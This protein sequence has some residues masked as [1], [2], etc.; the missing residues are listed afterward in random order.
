VLPALLTL[1]GVS[2]TA[3]G[4]DSLVTPSPSGT[5]ERELKKS[6]SPPESGDDIGAELGGT[7]AAD[8][9]DETAGGEAVSPIQKVVKEEE[10]ESADNVGG[11]LT[12]TREIRVGLFEHGPIAELYRLLHPVRNRLADETGI[13][14]GVAYTTL[15]QAVTA[16][17]DPREGLSG[18]FDFFGKWNLLN[19]NQPNT[20]STG[21]L[22]EYRHR[23]TKITPNALNDN[24]GS[25]WRTTKAFNSQELALV[26]LWWEQYLFSDHAK[27]VA[28][29]IDAANFYNGNR[30]QNQNTSFL[31]QAFSTNPTR[32]FP[33]NGLGINVRLAPSE[34]IY[35]SF[36]VH[37]ANSKKTSFNFDDL[38][39]DDLFYA[40]EFG[41]T[42]RFEGFGP[43][44]YRFTGWHI[45]PGKRTN[46]KSGSGFALSF[47]QDLGNSLVPFFRYGYQA[48]ELEATRQ[49]VVGG[50]GIESPF[51]WKDD[52]LGIGFA[53]GDPHET[54]L[55]DQYV[56]ELYLQHRLTP[57]IQFTP[58]LQLIFDPSFNRD[59][60]IIAIFEFRVRIVF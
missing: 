32:T 53:W 17:D 31:N 12:E 50:L 60:D 9:E 47:E 29:K 18:D 51:G 2:G 39:E 34:N 1:G 24:L 46:G 35:F 23:F 30:F 38:D 54:E 5:G 11:D 42:P 26:Q 8:A 6:E 25:L 40:V 20:G 13:N 33:N 4:Q 16:G 41:L 55:R 43:G 57:K 7:E 10:Q 59:D 21:F 14:L 15:F 3:S 28:G 52:V 56:M 36:G 58:G 45:G 48:D 44:R 22:V 27:V 37:D 49:I 19:R